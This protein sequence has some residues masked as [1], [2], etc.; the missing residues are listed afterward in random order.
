MVR[1]GSFRGLVGRCSEPGAVF[2]LSPPCCSAR[3]CC[4]SINFAG[5]SRVQLQSTLVRVDKGFL[6]SC[7]SYP[8]V[9]RLCSGPNV[10]VRDTAELSGVT[11]ECRTKGRC[12]R[13]LVSGCGACSRNILSQ[14]V[15]L[16]SSCGTCRGVLGRTGIV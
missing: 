12:P 3:S 11:R 10:V 2:C 15:A 8:R 7:G 1:G 16:F 4:R 9:H 6:L 5:T 14:R 13:L